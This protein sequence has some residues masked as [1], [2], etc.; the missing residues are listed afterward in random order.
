MAHLWVS[1]GVEVFFF[2]VWV[3]GRLAAVGE[4]R[5]VLE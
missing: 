3:P 2:S 5:E 1:T 4:V